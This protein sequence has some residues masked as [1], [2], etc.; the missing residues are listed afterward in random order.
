MPAKIALTDKFAQFQ[1]QWRPKVLATLNGQE[2]KLIKCQGEFPWHH[3][4]EADEFFLVWRGQLRRRIPR[5]YCA[6]RPRRGRAGTA[7]CRT[8]HLCR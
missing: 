4:E 1:E 2:I 6:A 5:S 8:P 3:H 7:R